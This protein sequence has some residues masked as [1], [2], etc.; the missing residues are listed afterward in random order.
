[1]KKQNKQLYIVRKYIMAT[2][3]KSAINLDKKTP[4]QDVWI[5]DEWKKNNPKELTPSIGFEIQTDE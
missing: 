2:S 3:A 4:V 1:M 5:D